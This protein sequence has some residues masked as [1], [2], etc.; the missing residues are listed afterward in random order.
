MPQNEIEA[1]EQEIAA[2]TREQNEVQ[3]RIRALQAEEDPTK[4]VF[5]AKEI[6]AAKQEKLR[7][8]FEIQFRKNRINRLKFGM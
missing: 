6:H 8:D 2:L 5:R 4:G 1:V 7:L 3:A